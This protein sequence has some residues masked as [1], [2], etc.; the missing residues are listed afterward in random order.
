VNGRLLLA[1]AGITGVVLM[2]LCL[3]WSLQRPGRPGQPARSAS[4][5][6]IPSAPG[7]AS[8]S[9]SRLTAADAERLLPFPAKQI[10]DAGQL[11]CEFTAAYGTYR[12]DEP[13]QRYVQR[14][15]PMMSPQ[16]RPAIERAAGDLTITVQRRRI[17][18]ISVGQAHPDGIRALGPSSVTFLIAATDQVTTAHATRQ[19]TTHYAVTLTRTSDGW[20]VYAIDLAATGNTGEITATPGHTP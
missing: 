1:A 15:M 16:L 7:A 13:P 8:A 11:A 20:L 12:Y 10:A 17:Q 3:S 14:L 4:P 5:S 6:A 2:L 9:P 19:D 18:E